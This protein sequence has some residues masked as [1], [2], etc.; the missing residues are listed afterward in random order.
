MSETPSRN[1]E[2]EHHTN[3]DNDQPEGRLAG[4]VFASQPSYRSGYE[5]Q[6]KQCS[7]D[8]IE[9]LEFFKADFPFRKFFNPFRIGGKSDV[10]L[11]KTSRA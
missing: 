7:D 11:A 10:S 1:Q 5:Y 2:L 4:E 6:Q 9:P 8:N 3:R